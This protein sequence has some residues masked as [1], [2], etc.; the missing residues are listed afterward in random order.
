MAGN[1]TPTGPPQGNRYDKFALALGILL[2]AHSLFLMGRVTTLEGELQSA[3][4]KATQD[5]QAAG[6]TIGLLRQEVG[7]LRDQVGPAPGLILVPPP[8]FGP[9]TIRSQLTQMTQ[10]LDAQEKRIKDLEAELAKAK[11]KANP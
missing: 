10:R 5:Q 1:P 8:L 4:F 9:P 2:L 11:E 7:Q 3:Q 6:Q